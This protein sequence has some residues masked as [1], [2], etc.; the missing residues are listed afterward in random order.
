MKLHIGVE[1]DNGQKSI[2][3]R[4]RSSK[5]RTI[6]RI[7][8]FC[9]ML[10]ALF[11]ANYKSFWNLVL[12]ERAQNK[13]ILQ[14]I[15]AV[16][17]DFQAS[18]DRREDFINLYGVAL[19]ALNQKIIGDFEFVKDSDGI[20]QLYEKQ[21]DANGFLGSVEELKQYLDRVGTPLIYVALPDKGRNLKLDGLTFNWQ[22]SK[23][24]GEML[25]G[26]VDILDVETLMESEPDAP[27]FSEFFF[28]TDLHA[29]TCA[30]FWVAKLLARHLEQAYD[31]HFANA[32]T[33][34][35]L[36]NY[37][38]SSYDF[39]GGN[40]RSAGK[41]F[42]GLDDFEIYIPDFETKLEL[43]NPSSELTRTGDFEN[44]MMN[45]Y[46]EPTDGSYM[47]WVTD[48]AQYPSPY[49]RYINHAVPE[50]APNVLIICDSVFLRGLSYLT[51][52]CS[53]LTVLDPRTFSGT[54]YVESTLME[55][56]YDAV[57]MIGLDGF[58]Y[59]SSFKSPKSLPDSS[60]SE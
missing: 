43:N 41:Y 17:T 25:T 38:I 7:A 28:K 16:E 47:Y 37:A 9:G 19:N 15:Q 2:A 3:D 20:I 26:K 45:G 34:F 32:Q 5:M 57:I 42:A 36:S 10:M 58:Y 18:V 49:Y 8:V 14:K 59:M 23:K 52:G 24:V 39:F 22:M 60:K 53:G 56:H 12:Q 48:F 51:L 1:N 29:A 44:V 27:A 55:Q 4:I 21:H 30:E 11:T 40:A 35:D 33:V 31:L 46:T 6:L 50:D 13:D 54:E